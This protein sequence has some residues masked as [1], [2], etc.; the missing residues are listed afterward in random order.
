MKHKTKISNSERKD[1]TMN[2]DLRG[3]IWV[4]TAIYTLIGLTLISIILSVAIP[5]VQK[6]KDRSILR[7]SAESLIDL[8]NELLKISDVAGNLRIFYFAFDKGRLE[9]NSS[10]DSISYR[11][12]NTN[13]KF[14]EPG[15][16]ILY[17]DITYET[18]T[19]GKKYIITLSLN[20]TNTHNITFKGKDDT[21]I[22]HNGIYKI[23]MENIGDIQPNQ[24]IHIDFD[25]V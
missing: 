13:Y 9:I 20:Y 15:K 16:K 4:E 23:K 18:Q 19:Y 1:K 24:K 10:G 25:V 6:I 12:E 17:G 2:Q 5:Q 7:Q 3:Q 22:I 8:T 11:L 14:S 21:Y